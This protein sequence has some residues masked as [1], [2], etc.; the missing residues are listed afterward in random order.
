M[1][2]FNFIY[3]DMLTVLHFYFNVFVSNTAYISSAKKEELNI[4]H[5]KSYKMR[6]AIIINS[7]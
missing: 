4:I 7:F 1:Q 6:R 2:S 5:L 3:N